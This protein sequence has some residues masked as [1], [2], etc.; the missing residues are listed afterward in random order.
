MGE[1]RQYFEEMES[2]GQLQWAV[3]I[4]KNEEEYF[5]SME[6]SSSS[7]SSIGSDSSCLSS[8]DG[9]DDASSSSNSCGPLYELS[10]LMSQLPMKRG[11]SKYYNGKS[12]TF[13]SLAN[14]ESLAKKET[15]SCYSRRMKSC[16]SSN[17]QR[18]FGPKRTITKR[19]RSPKRSCS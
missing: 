3:V 4:K 7:S 6:P 10:E 16:G 9:A 15:N 18:K 19:S 12:Q 8:S 5:E 14:I 2:K 13:A 11:L 1:E 17:N